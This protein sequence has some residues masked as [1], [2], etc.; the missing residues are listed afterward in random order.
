MDS[1]I[2][3]DIETQR[4]RERL[5]LIE[6][7]RK[8]RDMLALAKSN[9]NNN[10][11]TNTTNNNN[12]NNTSNKENKNTVQIK[13]VNIISPSA[14]DNDQLAPLDANKKLKRKP[15]FKRSTDSTTPVVTENLE[16]PQ[17]PNQSKN[18][19]QSSSLNDE[20]PPSRNQNIKSKSPAV[21]KEIKEVENNANQNQQQSLSKQHHQQIQPNSPSNNN[22]NNNNNTV[23]TKPQPQTN[24]PQIVAKP[25][26]VVKE[27]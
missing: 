8:K 14:K 11:S 3:L 21:P 6:M 25:K 13:R 26:E 24:L 19:T 27:P 15:K 17:L 7:E 1:D 2:L 16:L 23:S 22:N 20:H 9:D 4:Q 5:K 10:N 12:N 18:T